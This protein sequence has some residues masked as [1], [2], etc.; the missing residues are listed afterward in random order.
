MTSI[1]RHIKAEIRNPTLYN[2][3]TLD[4][5]AVGLMVDNSSSKNFPTLFCVTT[6]SNFGRL[7]G[8]MRRNDGNLIIVRGENST[9]DRWFHITRSRNII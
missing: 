4:M 3:V 7:H 9:T 8:Y 1:D 5:T 6:V 2:F